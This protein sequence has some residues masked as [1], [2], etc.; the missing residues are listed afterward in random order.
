MS[1]KNICPQS[2]PTG[3]RSCRNG[4]VKVPAIN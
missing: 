4:P 3:T 2:S 1:S